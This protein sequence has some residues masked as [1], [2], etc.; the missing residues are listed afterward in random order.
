MLF[1]GTDTK[2]QQRMWDRPVSE[3][4]Y[5]EVLHQAAKIIGDIRAKKRTTKHSC[6]ISD[7]F[8]DFD[9]GRIG[10]HSFKKTVVSLLVENGV[11]MQIISAITATSVS[12]LSRHYDSATD[13]RRRKALKALSP[14]LEGLSEDQN[15]PDDA[16]EA[17]IH[18][19]DDVHPPTVPHNYSRWCTGCGR[20]VSELWRFCYAC[21]TQ[22][23]LSTKAAEN[24]DRK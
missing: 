21:G 23:P 6:I 7:V 12:T 5:S 2:T 1:P 4:A 20:K 16:E 3:R 22:L 17:G 18:E 10:S 11:S 9:L 14:V 13:L 15:K 19:A 8:L 24:P